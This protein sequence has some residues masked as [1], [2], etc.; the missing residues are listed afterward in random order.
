MSDRLSRLLEK[1]TPQEQTEV[2]NFAIY[3][4]TRRKLHEVQILTE[5]ISTEELMQLAMAAG[6]FDWLSADEE[7]V[8]SVEDGEAVSW[9]SP[10]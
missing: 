1:M 7:D 2:E 8:Y 10:T 3:V 6:G 4:I 9:P 5:D